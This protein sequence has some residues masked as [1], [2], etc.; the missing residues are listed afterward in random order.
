MALGDESDKVYFA[1][2]ATTTVKKKKEVGY[3]TSTNGYKWYKIE[4]CYKFSFL[5]THH[6]RTT[7]VENIFLR[8]ENFTQENCNRLFLNV[9]RSNVLVVN[10]WQL[11]SKCKRNTYKYLRKM[12]EQSKKL[13]DSYLL[14]N[15]FLFFIHLNTRRYEYNVIVSG[16]ESINRDSFRRGS[17][18]FLIPELLPQKLTVSNR[19]QIF[20]WVKCVSLKAFDP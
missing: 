16:M 8:R 10:K 18:Q 3:S 12:I 17:G 14:S 9:Q 19:S 2:I 1:N 20:F 11:L 5:F 13:E 15:L 6:L 4:G 7:I